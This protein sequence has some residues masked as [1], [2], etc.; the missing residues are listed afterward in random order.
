MH[1]EYMKLAVKLYELGFITHGEL[2]EIIVLKEDII[3]SV[4]FAAGAVG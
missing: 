1:V 3:V 2:M 4:K